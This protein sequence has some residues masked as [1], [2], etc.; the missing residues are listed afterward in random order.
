MALWDVTEALQIVYEHY[1]ALI[2]R[3]GKY[4]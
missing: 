4:H 1:T 2:E 3:Y